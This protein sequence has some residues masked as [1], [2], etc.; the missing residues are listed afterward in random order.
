MGLVLLAAAIL[1]LAC[2]GAST[3]AM[4]RLGSFPQF[5]L[6][7]YVTAWAALVAVSAILSVPR[8]LERGSLTA[9]LVGLAAGAVVLWSR[10]R[11]AAPAPELHE[12]L[13]DPVVRVLAASLA[14]AGVY[15]GLLVVLTA[16]NDWDG[17][18]Y[19]ETRAVLWHQQDG[20]G[21]VPSGNDPR[22]DGN[23]PVSEIGLYLTTVVP[24]SER[25]GALPQFVALWASLIAVILI[26]RR[27]GLSRTEAAYGGLVFAT[28]PV[29]ILQGDAVLN[30]LLVASFLLAAVVF[31]LG[32][33]PVSLALGSVALGLA[34]STK[35]NAV[36]ALPVLAAVV[37]LQAPRDVRLRRALAVGLG[38]LLGAPWYVLNLVETGSFDGDLGATTGQTADH[39]FRGIVGSLRAYL[40]DAVDTSG[41]WRSEIYVA[42]LVG[43]AMVGFAVLRRARGASTSWAALA[44]GGLLT[45]LT[46]VLLRAL[47]SPTRDVWKRAW[48]KLGRTDIALDHGDAWNVLGRPDTSLSWYGAAGALIVLA[49]PIAAAV[50]FRRGLLSRQT[51][52]LALAPVIL[53]GIFAATITYDQWR[54]RLLMFAVG[55]ACAAWGWTMRFRWVSVGMCAL[56]VTTLALSLVH[57]FTKPSGMRLFERPDKA[58]VWGRDRIETL[59]V[60]RDL[61]GTPALLRAVE[62]HVPRAADLAVVMPRDSFLA[63]LAGARLSRTLHLVA[64]GDRIPA[65]ADWLVARGPAVA[66]GCKSAWTSVFVDE[67][68]ASRLL[69]RVAPDACGDAVTRL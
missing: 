34:L 31:L 57:S 24:R 2:L 63:P 7:A 53:I 19:H 49:G 66:V 51:L 50:G 68:H 4:L 43:A 9:C 6:A 33:E 5:A 36:L 44:A 62:E 30:D 45:S 22:L 29:V 55:L 41:L 23:P 25:L 58:A 14:V 35:F 39:S 3:A 65:R 64:E 61:D 13:R 15:L 42:V 52:L 46:P 26:G 16:P 60:I 69:H 28:L 12:A 32:R 18:T 20:I 56:C 54:G 27:I 10:R 1:S 17:L 37:L 8:W 11:H 21:Y 48:V 47:E 67:G 59:T 40:F 38:M